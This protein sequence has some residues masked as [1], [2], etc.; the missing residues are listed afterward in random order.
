MSNDTGWSLGIHWGIGDP[1][2]TCAVG[3]ILL[4]RQLEPNMLSQSADREE[5]DC[6]GLILGQIAMV[7]SN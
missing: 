1:Q 6:V 7:E 3:P 4:T 2:N 5:R